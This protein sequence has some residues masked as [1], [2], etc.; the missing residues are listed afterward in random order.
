MLYRVIDENN[1]IIGTTEYFTPINEPSKKKIALVVGHDSKKQ[2][3]YGD[4]GISEYRFNS[5]LIQAIRVQCQNLNIK[6][7][8]RDENIKGYTNQMIDLHRRLD[9][10]GSD[11]SIEFHFNAS[12]D[13]SVNGNE[14]LYCSDKGK[15]VAS[16]LDE[17]LDSL[18]NR[19]RG[20]KKV[21]MEDN[22]GGFCCRGKSV[23][24]IS[25]PFFADKYSFRY[26]FNSFFCCRR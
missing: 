22:G 7:F 25:E 21:T 15:R 16:I 8:Y 23:C 5:E 6:V 14:V 1:N 24:V 9:K 3:A 19:D 10:W 4:A 17:C 12:S 18:P 13:M 26:T 2:G 20:V 11:V